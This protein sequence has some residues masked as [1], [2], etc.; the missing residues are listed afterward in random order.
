MADDATTLNYVDDATTV[1][2]TADATTV[3]VSDDSTVVESAAAGAPGVGVPSGGTTGQALVKNSNA[4]YDTHWSTPSTV[5]A[6]D[7]LTDVTAPSP[8]SGDG[9]VW[10]GTAWVNVDVATQA[11]LNA[12]TG[13]TG[14]AVH[15]LGTASTHAAADFDAAGTASS[16]VSAHVAATDPHGDRAYAAGLVDDLSGVTNASTARTNL[17]LGTAA[18]KDVPASGNASSSQVV[19]G[20]DTRLTDNRTDPTKVAKAGDTMTGTLNMTG[21]V[22]LHQSYLSGTTDLYASDFTLTYDDGNSAHYEQFY[23]YAGSV[24]LVTRTGTYGWRMRNNDVGNNQWRFIL[25]ADG[26]FAWG[27]G[28]SAST[29]TNLYRDSAAVLRTDG[30]FRAAL[31]DGGTP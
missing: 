15:G 31:I 9:L 28:A 19:K 22:A 11:E 26:T 3:T 8:A 7:D 27:D 21:N 14:T 10:N 1:D 16:A 29:D 24:D 23:A 13:A 30:E 20:D 2:E 25:N 17:G 18:T 6:L 4:D 12:H 5:A